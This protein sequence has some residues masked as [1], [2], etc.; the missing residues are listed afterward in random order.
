MTRSPVSSEIQGKFVENAGSS[1]YPDSLCIRT[2]SGAGEVWIYFNLL[3]CVFLFEIQKQN[4][5]SL[6]SI[7]HYPDLQ[8]AFLLSKFTI[9]I[10]R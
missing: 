7:S 10:G 1:P 2:L 4:R 3:N 9:S 8:Q 6:Y 5:H